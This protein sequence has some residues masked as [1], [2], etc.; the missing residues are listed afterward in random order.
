MSDADMSAGDNIK[1]VA[2]HEKFQQ[3]YFMGHAAGAIC[4]S[5]ATLL[6]V[7]GRKEFDS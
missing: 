5:A 4:G 3:M 1:T 6:P 2:R 7:C